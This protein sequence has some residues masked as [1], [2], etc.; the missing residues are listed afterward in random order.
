MN[1][2]KFLEIYGLSQ[3]NLYIFQIV[4]GAVNI[5]SGMSINWLL[6][7]LFNNNG[8]AELYIKQVVENIDNYITIDVDKQMNK[9]TLEQVANL[10][11]D[12]KRNVVFYTSKDSSSYLWMPV[13]KFDEE[14]TLE[15]LNSVNFYQMNDT[16]FKIQ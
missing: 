16:T 12:E 9:L 11:N 10:S 5:N 2:N 13:L 4:N 6:K 3:S 8:Y 15:F 14:Y 7:E 1:F